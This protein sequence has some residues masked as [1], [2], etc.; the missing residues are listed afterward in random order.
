MHQA[1]TCL[2]KHRS[3]R[4]WRLF[5]VGQ[6]WDRSGFLRGIVP[7]PVR[8]PSSTLTTRPIFHTMN[9]YYIYHISMYKC[10]FSCLGLGNYPCNVC[11]Y[12]ILSFYIYAKY[13]HT[14]ISLVTFS[15]RNY[16]GYHP[17]RL[18]VPFYPS[19]IYIYIYMLYMCVYVCVLFPLKPSIYRRCSIARLWYPKGKPSISDS[20]PPRLLPIHFQDHI[21]HAP[22][23]IKGLPHHHAADSHLV[24]HQ[25]DAWR[26]RME[27]T[28]G[29]IP[30]NIW[31][32]YLWDTYDPANVCD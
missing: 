9:R 11:R 1:L 16:W 27:K 5:A 19:S 22:A 24:V 12:I 17:G 6:Q 21:S 7:I 15:F 25:V 26:M 4:H 32:K 28:P 10:G 8:F 14:L 31:N 13:I 30:N 18:K 29:D 20:H 2:I 23:S 3:K